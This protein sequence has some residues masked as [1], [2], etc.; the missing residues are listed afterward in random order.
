MANL[1]VSEMQQVMTTKPA[2]L[3]YLVQ[4]GISSNIN[5]AAFFGKIPDALFS[6]SV[7]L[8]TLESVVENGGDLEDSHCVTALTVDNIDRDFMLTSG[9]LGAPLANFMLKVVY[10]KTTAGGKA[11]IIGGLVDTV[12]KVVL[13]RKGDAAIFLSTPM[14]WIYLTGT[15]TV[16]YAPVAPTPPSF[17]F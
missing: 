8:D 3:L 10:L 6:G 13:S 11:N 7:Q 17:G 15:A 12:S 5:V 16:G 1:K 14:G 9:D 2:D 4:D